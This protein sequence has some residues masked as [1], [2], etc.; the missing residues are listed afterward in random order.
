[1]NQQELTETSPV[2]VVIP[3]AGEG[4][5]FM[6]A[7]YKQPK[8]FID[9]N[10]TMMIERALNSFKKLPARFVLVVPRSF[11]QTCHTELE[12]LEHSY[13]LKI[14]SV[15]GLTPGAAV[16]AL[17]AR[18]AVDPGTDIIFAD[19]D[20]FFEPVDLENF[21]KDMRSRALDGGLLT[22]FSAEPCYSYARIDA[23][24]RLLETREKEV[25]SPHAICGVYYFASPGIF[26]EAALDMLV[27]NERI[28]GEFYLSSVYNYLKRLTSRIGIFEIK[29]FS[30][31]GT[32]E[33]LK[34]YLNAL[35]AA[36]R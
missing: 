32:P 9:V 33:Q 22:C 18:R 4:R 6:Q 3:M 16:T 23:E 13:S 24:G 2:N 10:G 15:P 29:S 21:V 5:R 17:A 8:P 19:C 26:Q 20:N 12:S 31:V 11:L 14:V 30:C 36:V 28:R 7:G 35:R 27:A 25:I 34:L 1:M